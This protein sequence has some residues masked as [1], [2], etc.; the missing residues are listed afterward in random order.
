Q[1]A[2]L[3]EEEPHLD[4]IRT[5][6]EEVP[7]PSQEVTPIEE[8]APQD[9]AEV[10]EVGLLPNLGVVPAEV[11]VQL[12]LVEAVQEAVLQLA[13]AAHQEDLA[14]E[15]EVHQVSHQALDADEKASYYHIF[16]FCHIDILGAKR[17]RSAKI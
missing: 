1:E 7:L 5:L 8:E 13:E 4:L 17:N 9:Q 11:A 6:T 12:D 10:Q 16:M 14:L 3:L 2:T 15:V